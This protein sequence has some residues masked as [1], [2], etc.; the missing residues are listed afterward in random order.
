MPDKKIKGSPKTQ[1]SKV[2][3]RGETDNPFTVLDSPDDR[4]T[5]QTGTGTTLV[6]TDNPDDAK[7]KYDA[8]PK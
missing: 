5:K 1:H 6:E 7:T 3:H 4:I 8:E 2:Y